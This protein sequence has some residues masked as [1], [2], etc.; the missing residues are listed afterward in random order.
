MAGALRG[1]RQP[2]ELA[3]EAD[4]EI[5][6]VDH[7]LN[8]AEPLLVDL[9]AFERHQAA[10]RLLAGPQ[11]LAEQPHEFAPARRRNAAPGLERGLRL[12]DHR[13][14]VGRLVR[15]EPGERRTVDRRAHL[16]GPGFKAGGVETACF[17]D[18][19]VCHVP[20]SF[21]FVPARSRASVVVG[22]IASG[23]VFRCTMAGLPL[24]RARAKASGNRSPASTVSPWPP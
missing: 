4:G 9:A 22:V 16:Q 23:S 21:Q 5:A 3:R 13:D 17:E 8:L 2:V 20:L 10:Q 1:D 15:D 6:D 14:H 12:A 18:F 24:A 11:L 19:V 7:L